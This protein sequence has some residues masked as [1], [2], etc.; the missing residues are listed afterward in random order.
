ME[1]SPS[2]GSELVNVFLAIY[3]FAEITALFIRTLSV[4]SHDLKK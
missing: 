3:E 1:L 2:P 4:M